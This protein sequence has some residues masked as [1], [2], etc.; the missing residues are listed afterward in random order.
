MIAVVSAL[1]MTAVLGGCGLDGESADVTLRLVAADYGDSA[2]NSSEKYW[3]ALV[4]KYE[5]D[6]PGVRVEVSVHSWNDVDR[7]VKEM[8]EA[9]RAPDMAQIGAY[10]DYADDGLLYTADDLLS[11]PVQAGFASR[12]AS[13]GQVN[14]VQ[15]GMP[16]AASTR[17]LFYNKSLFEEAGLTPPATWEELADAAGA[18]KAEGV[19]YPYALPLGSE[20]A[21]AETMQWLLSGGGGYTDAVGTYGIDSTENV[22]TFTWLRDKLVGQG[23]TGPVAPGGLDR[24]DAFAAFAEGEVGMLNGHPS[25]MKMAAD[26]GVKFGM[27]PMP[28]LNGESK[29]TMGVADWMLAF[30]QN[31]HREEVGEFLDFVYS[32]KNVLDLSR[33]YDLLPVTNAASEAMGRSGEDREIKPFLDELPLAEF[34]PVGK[35]SW[36]AV[37]AEVKK[38]IG[39][40]VR[41]GGSPTTILGRLQTT[42][43]TAESAAAG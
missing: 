17:L 42:A 26:K 24:A 18:L 32:D 40:A 33:R 39:T 20:E 3:S 25:L 5:A 34:Y 38:R 2:A 10:A 37:S 30:K 36:A 13:A 7:E 22:E 27:V 28:G 14:G 1:G 19:E 35:T 12:L 4:E 9:G 21:Q 43:T 6:H 23:L 11:I 31:G 15:Y 29:A 16:F 41:Q 8:V